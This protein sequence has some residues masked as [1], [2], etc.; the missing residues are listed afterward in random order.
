LLIPIYN[1]VLEHDGRY[2]FE[3]CSTLPGRCKKYSY[4]PI[5]MS[6]RGYRNIRSESTVDT[7]TLAIMIYGFLRKIGFEGCSSFFLAAGHDRLLRPRRIPSYDTRSVYSVR[8]VLERLLCTAKNK[9]ISYSF[10]LAQYHPGVP[11][12]LR[13]IGSHAICTKLWDNRAISIE[14]FGLSWLYEDN[15]TSVSLCWFEW[16]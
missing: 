3:L 5:C 2:T 1:Y 10:L 16:N 15:A 6:Y 14:W 9:D 4:K 8:E 11:G 13:S 12:L 7:D